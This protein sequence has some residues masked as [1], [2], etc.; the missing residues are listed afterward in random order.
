MA[1]LASTSAVAGGPVSAA[2]VVEDPILSSTL[3]VELR[4]FAILPD[5]LSGSAPRINSM[6]STGDRLFAVTEV[7]GIV[8]ELDGD[9]R[10][11][12]LAA[13]SVFF[14][15]GAA[16]RAATGRSLDTSNAAH[17]GLRSLAFHPGFAT[18]GLLYVSAME[19]RP[20]SSAG[21]HYLSDANVGV[22]ADSVVIEFQADPVTG[23]VDP[24]SYREVF[25]VGIPAYDHP[26]KQ[27]SFNPFAR[28]GDEDFGLLYIGHGDGSVFSTETG[29]GQANDALGKILRLDPR[30]GPTLPY[31]IPATNPFVG[32]PTMLDVVF[33][34][35]HRNPHTLSFA[36][37]ADGRLGGGATLVVGEPGRDNVE[38]INEIESGA[39]YGWPLREGSFVHL[40]A[41]V[42]SGVAELPPDEVLQGFTYPSAQYGHEGEVG[43]TITGEA[44]AGGYTVAN[45]SE[46]S[47]QYFYADFA[48]F[49]WL[50]HTPIDELAG[51]I[52]RLE[53]GTERDDPDDLR[54][55]T[56][57][58]VDLI[59][60]DHDNN[61]S[62]SPRV[63]SSLRSLFADTPGYETNRADVRFGQGPEGELYITSKRNNTVY[64]VTNSVP[65]IPGCGAIDDAADLGE[66]QEACS[67]AAADAEVLRLYRAFFDREPEIG[68]ARYW[69]GRRREG[70]TFDGIAQF[71]SQSPEFVRT[72]G[73]SV[74]DEEFLTIIYRNA[75]GRRYDQAGFDFWLRRIQQ[76][77]LR[78]HLVVRFVA[79]SPEF[80]GR[81]PYG[82]G[83]G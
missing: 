24:L 71:F 18:N 35:G 22:A 83:S 10:S 45:G 79:G 17:G 74:S 37:V 55:A 66:L 39:N 40:S 63:R 21:H 72:Y 25:R 23:V 26:I 67:Y 75:L 49:G 8:Y 62:T 57:Q 44:V 20:S 73:S 80:V 41:G 61:S 38:E 1:T 30:Q 12:S 64:L 14:D 16:I 43:A 42:V 51:A 33:S 9:P 34:L 15:A 5:A 47:G 46:L 56:V 48:V 4:Q 19:T 58:R 7:D 27:I 54:S 2:N 59:D 11:P 31:R 81:F 68:G 69:L 78:R 53:P 50:L 28:L 3:R 29:T 76:D 77:G 60:F 82:F 70:T 32:D 6:A 13:V 36:Q 52:T 65:P